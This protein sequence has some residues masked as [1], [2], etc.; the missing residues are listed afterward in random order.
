[1]GW[2]KEEGLWWWGGSSGVKERVQRDRET[3]R[4]EVKK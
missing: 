1:M 2:R 3:G 4:G